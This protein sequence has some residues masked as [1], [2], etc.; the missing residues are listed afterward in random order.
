MVGK[1]EGLH[2][3]VQVSFKDKIGHCVTVK[4]RPHL[5]ALLADIWLFAIMH[6]LISECYGCFLG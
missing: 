6:S 3:Q 4:V 1:F 5:L 2:I